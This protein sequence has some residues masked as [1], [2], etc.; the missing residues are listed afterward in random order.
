MKHLIQVSMILI[1]VF[2]LV[3][4]KAKTE[5]LEDSQYAQTAVSEPNEPASQS[6][7]ELV[8]ESIAERQRK[9]GVQ[10]PFVVLECRGPDSLWI[11]SHQVTPEELKTIPTIQD[12]H[13]MPRNIILRVTKDAFPDGYVPVFDILK[14]AEA[15]KVTTELIKG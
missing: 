3:G 14:P 10:E 9:T 12:K 4:C 2:G 11:G 1:G 8:L 5:S 6:F 15:N 13:K 7:T